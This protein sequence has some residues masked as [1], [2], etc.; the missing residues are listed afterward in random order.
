MPRSRSGVVGRRWERTG[1][2]PVTA[3]SDLRLRLLLSSLFLPVFLAGTGL[4][5][6]WMTQTGPGE[7]PSTGSLRTLT[8]ICAALSLFALTDLAVVLRRRHRERSH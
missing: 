5:W 1:T 6:W 8:L 4:F 7:A 3:R 2:E